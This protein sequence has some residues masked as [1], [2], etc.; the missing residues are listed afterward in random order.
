MCSGARCALGAERGRVPGLRCRQPPLSHRLAPRPSH[1]SQALCLLHAPPPRP[2]P[3]GRGQPVPDVV[4]LPVAGQHR[5]GDGLLQ[6][7]PL[8]PQGLL[9]VVL[10][11]LHHVAQEKDS[12]RQALSLWEGKGE[13]LPQSPEDDGERWAPKHRV[14]RQAV[15]RRCLHL[16]GGAGSPGRW[17]PTARGAGVPTSWF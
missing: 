6:V 2:H 14:Q 11:R 1:P 16:R 17:A 9:E 12:A 10:Q 7:L 5:V 3:P 4:G 15:C 8:L 13:A